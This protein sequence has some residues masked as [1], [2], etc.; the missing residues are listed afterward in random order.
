MYALIFVMIPILAGNWVWPDKIELGLEKL[1]LEN[2]IEKLTKEGITVHLD[3]ETVENF[4]QHNQNMQHLYEKGITMNMGNQTF[5]SLVLFRRSCAFSL[6]GLC[7]TTCGIK[8]LYDS[9]KNIQE[10]L[11]DEENANKPWYKILGW[12]D[13]V[14]PI[15]GLIDLGIG[16][17][18]ISE[19]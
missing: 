11:N 8:L 18:I 17:K 6:I 9:C 14:C 4:K 1:G 5:D 7:F 10:K 15:V 13:A 19:N 16:Y 2:A 3:P 12:R